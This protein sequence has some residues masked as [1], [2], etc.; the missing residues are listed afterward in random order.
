MTDVPAYFEEVRCR[1]AERWDQLEQDPVLAGPWHQLFK[2]VQIPRHV[3]SELLQNADDA[4]ATMAAVDIQEGDFVFTHN[5]EDFIEEHFTSLCR[6]GYSNKRALHTIGFRGIGFKSTFSLGDEVRLNTPSLSVAF[7]RERFTEPVWKARNGMPAS[8]TEIRVA[9]RDDHRLRELEKNLEDWTKSP[10]S[11]LFFRSIR[12]MTVRGH[13]IRWEAKSPGPIADSHWMALASDSDRQFLLIQSKPEAFPEEALEEIR[14]ERMVAVDEETSFPPCK[15]EIVLGL[16]GRLFVILPTGVKTELPFACNAPFIQDP[17]RLKIKDPETSPTNRWLLERVGKLATKAML[18]WLNSK[19]LNIKQRCKAYAL[20]PDLDRDNHSIEGSCGRIVEEACKNSLVDELYLVAED[21]SLEKGKGCVALP[22]VLLDVWSAEQVARLFNDDARPILSRYVGSDHRRK[23]VNWNSIDE[24]GKEDVLG[25]LKSKHL[26]KPES[27]AQLLVLWVY[28]ADDVVGYH[29]N[30]NHKTVRIFP[31]QGKDVLF[32]AF[33]LVRLGEKK[34]LQSQEDWQFLANYL[35]VLNQNWPRYLAEQRR[36]AEQDKV[37]T[38]GMQVE[39]AYKIL[40]AL[41]LGQASDVSQVIQQVAD[42]FFEENDCDIEDCIRLAQLAAKLG[43]TVTAHFQ[44]LTRDGHIKPVSVCIVYD[45]HNDLDAFV[46]DAWYEGHV[47]H[48]DYRVLLSCTE[49]EWRQWVASGRSRLLTFVPLVPIQH[50][51]WRRDEIKRLLRKR[52]FESTPSF[53]YKSDDF[54]VDDWDFDDARWSFWNSSAMDNAEFWGHLFTRVLAQPKRYWEN[55]LCAKVWQNGRT[56]KKPVTNENLLP[57]W[58][59]K[60]SDLPCLQDTRGS[61][62]QP[63]ELLRRTPDTE[64]LL[65]VEPFVRA[66]L[67]TETTRQV[68]VMLGVRDTPT[69][70]DRLLDR[71]R[72]LATVDEPPVYEVEKWCHRLDQMLARCSTEEIQEIRGVFTHEKIILTTDSEWVYTSEVFLNADEEDAPGAAVVHSTIRDLA[73]WRKVG[74]AER[75]TGDLA[76]K[77]LDGIPSN[78]KLSKDELRRVRALLPRYAERIWLECR[79]WLNLDG[80]WAPVE[81]LVYK[82]TMQTLIP[83]ANLFRPIKQ[84]TADLQKLTAGMCG[85]YPFAELPTLAA[86]IEDRFEDKIVESEDAI[87][88][89]WLASLGSGLAR[90]VLDDEADSQR[91]RELGRRLMH[92]KWQVVA[93]L[94]TTP[95]I[96]GTPSGTP[97]RIDVLWNDTTLYVKSK[98]IA[99]M[100]KAVAQELGRAFGRADIA[101]SIKLC[102]ERDQAF[103]T[104]YIEENFKLLPPEEIS[105]EETGESIK[106]DT[107]VQSEDIDRT[108]P[109]DSEADG[110]AHNTDE[111]TESSQPSPDADDSKATDGVSS[112]DQGEPESDEEESGGNAPTLRRQ[113][114]RPPKTKLIERYAKALGF[115]K[116]NAEGRFYHE[117]G[118]WIERVSGA[119]FPWDRYS[120]TG[121]LHQC[122]WVK[123]HCIEREPLQLEADVWELCDKHPE[124]YTLLLAGPDGTPVEYSGHRIRELRDSGRLTL[125]PANYR[126]VLDSDKDA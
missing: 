41:G 121:E 118:N 96:D 33:E 58:V 95:Y 38:L 17:A 2:Q 115:S 49:D 83:W 102:F 14:Q 44:Y 8:H 60:F 15:I 81:D 50:R 88:K 78:K 98:S 46:D 94:E 22:R 97:R 67:D 47:L 36:K 35:L 7:R 73:L 61:Y 124:K 110:E 93:A 108:S 68:L 31:A 6:F 85:Q 24:V 103:V 92:T 57:S 43:A 90:V 123:D 3:V 109:S 32:S 82:L 16:E 29:Y 28:V 20:L 23:L 39:T 25:T 37:E 112:D 18:E 48:E 86:S 42:K 79:H 76:L 120:A 70:P 62:R 113:P 126:L 12:C 125:F 114:Q 66:E 30:R 84:K 34:L 80:E 11:L 100:A 89:Q 107:N 51:V 71:L 77:W 40:D 119:S 101:D 106:E 19:D 116:D 59:I 21:G 56:Y 105:T 72:A 13:E 45:V 117:D 74:V 87:A 91:T 63:A 27:W 5:G 69:G 54:T 64:S 9:I 52:G 53:L 122:Y 75:P 55:A 65:D 26:P 99:K 111:D 4:G 10:A 1:A 104:E